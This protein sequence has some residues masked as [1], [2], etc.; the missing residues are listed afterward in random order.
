MGR[1]EYWAASAPETSPMHPKRWLCTA[2][3]L[4]DVG[5]VISQLNERLRTPQ[6]SQS[7]EARAVEE[8]CNIGLAAQVSSPS[9]QP[10][11]GGGS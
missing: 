10:P 8:P 1:E 5:G 7:D 2:F 4:P 6:R 3:H 11:I 9:P